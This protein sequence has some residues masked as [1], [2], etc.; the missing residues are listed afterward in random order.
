MSLLAPNAASAD[1]I[2]GGAESI[3]ISTTETT[4]YSA[5]SGAEEVIML[6][7]TVPAEPPSPPVI[8]AQ[9]SMQGATLTQD[10]KTVTICRDTENAYPASA[11]NGFSPISV[12]FLR[13]IGAKHGVTVEELKPYRVTLVEPPKHGQV[14]LTSEP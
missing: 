3:I 10:V 11:L 9:A 5:L 13:Q 8:I 12:E 7:F 14:R 4:T 6:A 1:A 2:V